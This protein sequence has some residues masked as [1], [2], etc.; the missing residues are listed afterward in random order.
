MFLC[1][2]HI[3]KAGMQAA[4]EKGVLKSKFSEEGFEFLGYNYM[5]ESHSHGAENKVGFK[6]DSISWFMISIVY[7]WDFSISGDG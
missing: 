1:C 5:K 7:A 4:I 6:E 2:F 3:Y